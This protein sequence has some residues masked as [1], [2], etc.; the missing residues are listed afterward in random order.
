MSEEDSRDYVKILDILEQHFIP[1][2]NE[3]VIHYV[4]FSRVLQEGESLDMFVTELQTDCK[5]G[6]LRDNLIQDRIICGLRDVQVKDRLLW[7]PNLDLL[8]GIII[9]RATELA[10]IH[11]RQF[12]GKSGIFGV[13]KMGSKEITQVSRQQVIAVV[14][15]SV[16]HVVRCT[17]GASAQRTVNSGIN[18]L[19]NHKE[20]FQEREKLELDAISWI[21]TSANITW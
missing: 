3:T 6:D 15:H 14:S 18:G 4:F 9:I 20:K 13:Q 16:R 19:Q 10:D 1:T 17:Y 21:A 12:E 7:D 8:K 2:A 5:F 11:I